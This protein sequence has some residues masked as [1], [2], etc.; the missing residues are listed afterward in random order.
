M[1][2]I[3]GVP[4]LIATV[5]VHLGNIRCSLCGRAS[6]YQ[7]GS[8]PQGFVACSWCDTTQDERREWH[9]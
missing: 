3:P 9:L 6:C 2:H 4:E 8:H 7:I 1:S 5:G